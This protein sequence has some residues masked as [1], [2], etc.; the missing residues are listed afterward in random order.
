MCSYISL[1][2]STT[3]KTCKPVIF[4]GNKTDFDHDRVV[5]KEH[6]KSVAQELGGGRIKHFETSTK[7]NTNVTEVNFEEEYHPAVYI[8]FII[9]HSLDPFIV[10]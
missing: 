1:S 5:S 7:N 4:V 3:P 10:K 9:L 6:G 2:Q 8:P